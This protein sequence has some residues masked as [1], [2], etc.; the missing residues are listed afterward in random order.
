MKRNWL[1]YLVIFSLALNLGTIGTLV[2]MR[3]HPPP[4]PPPPPEAAPMPFRQM[5]GE[6]QLNP[7]QRQLFRGMAPEHWRKVRELQQ[8][9]AR[10]RQELFALIKQDNLPDW[11]PVQTKIREIGSLQLRLEEAKVQHLLEVQKN[12][13]PEQRRLLVTNLERRLSPFWGQGGRHRGPMRHLRQPGQEPGPP[14]P[15]GP[16]PGPAGEK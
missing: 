7:Q 9:L 15:P 4:P 3:W 11:P 5:L 1:L 8:E 14:C 6:L 12:L 16:P 2:Y 10:Q 13:T